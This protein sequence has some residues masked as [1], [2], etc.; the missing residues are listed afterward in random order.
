MAPRHA[1]PSSKE[2]ESFLSLALTWLFLIRFPVDRRSRRAI[3]FLRRQVRSYS[4]RASV[5]SWV[6]AECTALSSSSRDILCAGLTDHEVLRHCGGKRLSLAVG[7]GRHSGRIVRYLYVTKERLEGKHTCAHTTEYRKKSSFSLTWQ[8]LQ[9][10]CSSPF[11]FA[12]CIREPIRRW[13]S[14]V[15]R[16]N[17]LV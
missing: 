4:A 6:G 11:V 15:L 2:L 8:V 1:L 14:P 5:S 9:L 12:V 7:G 3:R 13:P 16:A 17:G 10:C